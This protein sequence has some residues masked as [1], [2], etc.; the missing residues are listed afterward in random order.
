[1]V[2]GRH[3]VDAFFR[4]TSELQ[5]LSDRQEQQPSRGY[6]RNKIAIRILRLSEKKNKY[7]FFFTDWSVTEKQ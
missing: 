7:F 5:E 6:I 4:V 3:T 2:G 1:M